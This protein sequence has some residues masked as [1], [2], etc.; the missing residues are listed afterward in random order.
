M[1]M[2]R[3][4]VL[5]ALAAAGRLVETRISPDGSF[6]GWNGHDVLCHLAAHTRLVGAILAAE[7]DGQPPTQHALYGR[8]LSPAEQALDDLDEVNAA[9]QREYA[10]LS[11]T[12]ALAFWQAMHAEALRQAARLSDAQ[13]AAP[14]PA[15]V[16]RW[17]RPHLAEVVAA[18]VSHYHG[19]LGA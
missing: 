18:L 2:T 13:L 16:P 8:E 12:E 7:A 19:H 11:Y 10:G 3:R 14:G 6:G 15:L 1:A 4:G 17:S 5:E 9:I